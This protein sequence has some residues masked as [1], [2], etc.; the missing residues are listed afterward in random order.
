M[1][2][3]SQ[4]RVV[5]CYSCNLTPN[6]FPETLSRIQKHDLD[7][8]TIPETVSRDQKHDLT[9]LFEKQNLQTKDMM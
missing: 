2:L 1:T 9:L 7:P 6:S 4:T 3:L 8:D 5:A